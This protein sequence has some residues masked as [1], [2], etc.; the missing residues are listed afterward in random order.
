MKRKTKRAKAKIKA[1]DKVRKW[2]NLLIQF[3]VIEKKKKKMEKRV[4]VTRLAPEA[5]KIEKWRLNEADRKS[6]GELLDND[7]KIGSKFTDGCQQTKR[8]VTN[9]S[10]KEKRK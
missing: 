10:G 9:R 4:L 8:A 1:E 6:N 7:F 3:E 5:N 2:V